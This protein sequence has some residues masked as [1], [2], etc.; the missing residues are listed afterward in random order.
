MKKNVNIPKTFFGFL[1][2]SIFFWLL[3]NLS[4]EYNAEVEYD[5]EYTQLPQQKTLIDAPFNKLTLNVKSSGYNLLMSSINHKPI[6]LQL[7]KAVKKK[8]SNYY[9]LSKNLHPEI[10]HQLKHNIELNSITQ[11]TIPVKIGLLSS[12]K[13]PLK[14]NVNI[15]F[16]LGYG[17]SKPLNLT[18]DSILISGDETDVNRIEFLNLDSATLENISKN[19]NITSSIL[20]PE[21]IQLKA[22]HKLVDIELLVDKFTEGE[23]EV[24]VLVKNAPKGINI[25]PK[26]VKVIYKV[27]LKNFNE[28][29]PDLFKIECDYLDAENNE[30]NY[31]TPKLKDTPNLATVLRIVPDKID[32]LIYE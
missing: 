25:F 11:D 21:N 15:S 17:L 13:V 9:F 14:P 16:Q 2:A 24:P 26:K 32:F 3:I 23:I 5:I 18:P 31:L 19:T 28:I 12:K 8:G 1:I 22:S 6:T 10:Q 30:L 4:K 20:F 7:D 29:T 27:G